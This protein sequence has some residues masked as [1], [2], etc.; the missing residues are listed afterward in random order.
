MLTSSGFEL[1]Q[2]AV[3]E[4]GQALAGAAAASEKPSAATM[5][6]M[7]AIAS[8]MRGHG[9]PNFP[10]PATTMPPNPALHPARVQL[11]RGNPKRRDLGDPKVGRR[12]VARGQ[13]RRGRLRPWRGRGDRPLTPRKPAIVS[14]GLA[15]AILARSFVIPVPI[16]SEPLPQSGR[17]TPDP[18][19]DPPSR[20]RSKNQKQCLS[21]GSLPRRTTRGNEART[22]RDR[23]AHEGAATRLPREDSANAA[24]ALGR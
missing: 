11:G 8:C 17:A 12:P 16:V 18:T 19:I 20:I 14:A 9:V 24:S 1:A 2:K 7:L 21:G 3:R 15:P 5:A 23:S 6:Q 4:L 22:S 10:D 13:T